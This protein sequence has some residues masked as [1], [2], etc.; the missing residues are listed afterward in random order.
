[1]DTIGGAS[2]PLWIWATYLYDVGYS[3]AVYHSAFLAGKLHSQVRRFETNG[4]S[5]IPG[6]SFCRIQVSVCMASR[7]RAT[8]HFTK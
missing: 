2:L 8:G 6:R 7:P 3:Q 4:L 5:L 1:M